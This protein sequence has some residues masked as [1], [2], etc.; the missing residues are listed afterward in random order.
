[1]IDMVAT[2]GGIEGDARRAVVLAV[3]RERDRWRELGGW[4]ESAGFDLAVV[5][6]RDVSSRIE[7]IEVGIV[8]V[9]AD[10][11]G[12]P[13]LIESMHGTPA[14][15]PVIVLT[16]TVEF[17]AVVRAFRSGAVDV[18]QLPIGR[19]RLIERL[20]EAAQDDYH[21]AGHR[22]L[23][24]RLTRLVSSLT[25]RERQVMQCVVEGSANK[26]IAA[27]LGIS[28]K[29][30]EVHRHKVM[31]KMEADSLASLVRMNMV[32]EASQARVAG[33]TPV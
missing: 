26:Q 11:P 22:R 19:Q 32:I 27:D 12:F 14:A 23:Y 30:V 24:R 31:R 16:E 29:T 1:M 3:A 28:E 17:D 15:P 18:L 25:P 7:R 4:I 5:D 33:S 8:V 20:A 21:R 10:V 13:G 9:D 6:A 2:A